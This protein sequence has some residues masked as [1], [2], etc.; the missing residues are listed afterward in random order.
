MALELSFHPLQQKIYNDA[1]RFKVISCGRRF[2]KSIYASQ[3]AIIE[4][5]RRKNGEIIL[6]SPTFSQTQII[7][8]MIMKRLPEEYIKQKSVAEK[9]VELISGTR[10]YAKSGDKWLYQITASGSGTAG[11]YVRVGSQTPVRICTV[12]V[13]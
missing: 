3:V 6:V 12:T 11:V 8:N 2:G 7:Y 5:L 9:Y 4:G 10:I 13:Q 1:R